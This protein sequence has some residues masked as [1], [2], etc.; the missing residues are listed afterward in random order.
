MNPAME[1]YS[2]IR[3]AGYWRA[4]RRSR[5]LDS[6]TR[7]ASDLHCRAPLLMAHV[8]A[9][10]FPA[11]TRFAVMVGIGNVGGRHRMKPVAIEAPTSPLLA[12]LTDHIG[13]GSR[14]V[15]E[16]LRRISLSCHVDTA[17]HSWMSV[18]MPSVRELR[19]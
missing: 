5:Q 17:S 15:S 2:A 16:R 9:V 6:S 4:C 1:D 14:G 12:R 18:V 8:T 7:A 11:S 13:A 10:R 19:R 3:I